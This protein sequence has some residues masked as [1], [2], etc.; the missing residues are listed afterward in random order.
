MTIPPKLAGV[1]SQEFDAVEEQDG[2]MQEL[3]AGP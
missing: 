3:T 1:N 2:P